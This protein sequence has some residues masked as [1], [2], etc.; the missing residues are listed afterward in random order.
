MQSVLRYRLYFMYFCTEKGET[1]AY[2]Q[3][4]HYHLLSKL[5]NLNSAICRS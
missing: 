5:G 2:K 1:Y 3:E 4:K